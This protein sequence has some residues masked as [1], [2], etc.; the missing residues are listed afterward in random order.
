MYTHVT[1]LPLPAADDFDG[2][3]P[4]TAWQLQTCDYGKYCCRGINDRRSCCNNATAPKVTTTLS[5]TLQLPPPTPSPT[6]EDVL[7]T[8][9][10]STTALPL[11]KNTCAKEKRE[12]VIVG[13][14]IG[15]LFG[16]IIAALA[17]TILWMY[18]REKR[19]RKLK[20]HYEQQ[21][22]QTNAYRK[23]LASSAGSTRGSVSMD[24]LKYKSNPEA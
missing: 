23:A 10:P 2:L 16:A 24:G 19:Q 8:S 11:D 21:F 14:T 7:A 20:E 15:T 3:K 17:A 13:S 6:S 18:K 5:A 4:V 12:T 22:S 1:N 9:T